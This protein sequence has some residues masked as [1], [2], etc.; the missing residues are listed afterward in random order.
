MK[1]LKR[2][3]YSLNTR[4]LHA[5]GSSHIKNI[6]TLSGGNVFIYFISIFSIPITTRL[7]APGDYGII[8]KYATITSIFSVFATSHYVHAIHIRSRLKDI[9]NLVFSAIL[10]NLVYFALLLSVVFILPS[11]FLAKQLYGYQSFAYLLP[12]SIFVLAL[13]S[14]IENFLVKLGQYSKTVVFRVALALISTGITIGVGFAKKGPYGLL[15]TLLVNSIISFV[16]ALV[17]LLRHHRDK[18]KLLSLKQIKKVTREEIGV[19]YYLFPG[20]ILNNLV[21]NFPILLIDQYSNANLIGLFDFAKRITFLPSQLLGGAVLDTMKKSA[22]DELDKTG[23]SIRTYL[24][25]LKIL[26]IIATPPLFLFTFF[27][28]ILV[29]IILPKKWHDSVFLIQIIGILAFFHTVCNPLSY[30][31]I[32]MRKFKEDF[33]TQVV[34]FVIIVGCLSWFFLRDMPFENMITWYAILY[35]AFFFYLSIRSYYF[36]KSS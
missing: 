29:E 9:T 22:V 3:F 12:I 6:A 21:K 24:R 31:Y 19:F 20:D 5:F 33:Y 13:N 27:S 7:Y 23:K 25:S 2:Y 14:I 10:I 18:R 4:V 17:Y 16:F 35:S 11:S 15:I 1:D 36:S 30:M 28:P 8:A 26:L 34:G 32:L